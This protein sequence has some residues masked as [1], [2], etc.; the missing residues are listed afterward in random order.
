MTQQIDATSRVRIQANNKNLLTRY[1]LLKS[2]WEGCTKC[3]LHEFRTNVVHFRGSL[4]CEVLF[5]G[6]APGESE[7]ALRYPFVGESGAELDSLICQIQGA[8]GDF[9]YGITNIVACKPVFEGCIREPKAD[10][11]KTCQP[12]LE[13]IIELCEPSLFVT[14]GKVAQRFIPRS[15]DRLISQV[16][17]PSFII[18]EQNEIMKN[19][20]RKRFINTVGEAISYFRTRR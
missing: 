6:E 1:Q 2:R 15:P 3:P 9:T 20:H 14:L 12:R 10:E 16:V 4:P 5:V 8:R 17:H 7:D 19:M 11:A 13:E 18:R